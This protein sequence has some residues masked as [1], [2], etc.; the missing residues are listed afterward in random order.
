MNPILQVVLTIGC[1]IGSYLN[2]RKAKICF[3]IWL[4]CNLGWAYVDLMN[5]AYSR[6]ALDLIHIS[7]NVYG[8]LQWNKNNKNNDAKKEK[9]KNEN[10]Q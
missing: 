10:E 9:K 2:C 8:L 3:I 5:G 1:L 4:I 7:F 6:M